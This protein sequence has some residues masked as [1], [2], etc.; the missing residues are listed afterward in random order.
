MNTYIYDDSIKLECIDINIIN[1]LFI[2]KKDVYIILIYIKNNN[3]Y[4]FYLH[5][6]Y[7]ISSSRYIMKWLNWND[8]FTKANN[9]HIPL[10]S[11]N[12]DALNYSTLH[13][14]EKA[15][16]YEI[17]SGVRKIIDDSIPTK[18]TGFILPSYKLD[19]PPI[20]SDNKPIPFF[21]LRVSDY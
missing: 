10:T 6:Y 5:L 17:I 11:L 4:I 14:N 13:I 2:Q 1:N 7:K 8:S 19:K 9:N 16:I 12:N 3:K 20:D 21:I 15:F 18:T